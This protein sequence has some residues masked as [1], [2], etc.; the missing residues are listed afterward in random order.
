MHASFLWIQGKNC[1]LNAS[2]VDLF[3]KNEPQSTSTKNMVHLAQ[4]KLV[5][6]TYLITNCN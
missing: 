6:P 1:C 5:T 4:S 2:T 3:L